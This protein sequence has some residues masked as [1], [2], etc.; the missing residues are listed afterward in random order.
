MI[1]CHCV[2]L[3]Q[4]RILNI[5]WSMTLKPACLGQIGQILP[6]FGQIIFHVAKLN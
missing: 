3:Y 2:Y 6:I 1:S 5:D 4:Y